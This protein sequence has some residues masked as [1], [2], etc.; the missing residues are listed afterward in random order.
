MNETIKIKNGFDL[1][2]KIVSYLPL[3][4]IFLALTGNTICFITFRFCKQFNRMPIMVYLSFIA[5]LDTSS[6]FVWNLNHFLT[7]NFNILIEKI[8]VFSCKFFSFLQYFSLQASANILSLM[9]IDRYITISSTP[10]S[11]YSKL[12]FGTI[13]SSAI[14]CCTVIF[15]IFILNF[16]LLIFNSLKDTNDFKNLTFSLL[17]NGTV[18]IP[19]VYKDDYKECYWYTTEWRII[20]LWD[21]L[22]L[23]IY[24]FFPFITMLLF[25]SLLVV[26][27][28]RQSKSMRHLKNQQEIKNFV[29]KRKL[30]ISILSITFLFIIMTMPSSIV[31]G[32]YHGNIIKLKYGSRILNIFDFVSFLFHSS[33]FFDCFVTNAKFRRFFMKR[34]VK[35]LSRNH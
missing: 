17:I 15:I 7:P 35:F 29:R 3:L 1:F 13:K 32:F 30:T 6:L 34:I 19:V 12:P 33:L 11:I 2:E 28:L 16:H 23:V 20:P 25:D 22:N 14:W 9:C 24:N 5:I 31:F 26:K 4:V 27:T 21:R 8:N 18:R 10:G